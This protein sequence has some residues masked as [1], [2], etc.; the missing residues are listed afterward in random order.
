MPN[1]FDLRG[2]AKTGRNITMAD[3]D[4]FPLLQMASSGQFW[5]QPAETI[6][7]Q[8]P[9]H[10][11]LDDAMLYVVCKLLDQRQRAEQFPADFDADGHV[12]T[13]RYQ[14][15]T[16]FKIR[17][18]GDW[19]YPVY[20]RYYAMVGSEA[21]T[22]THETTVAIAA[23]KTAARNDDSWV[24]FGTKKVPRSYR[25]GT[26]PI[27]D[28]MTPQFDTKTADGLAT[29][30]PAA[31]APVWSRIEAE[32]KHLRDF[33]LAAGS[34][35]A[36]K[37]KHRKTGPKVVKPRSGVKTRQVTKETKSTTR[38]R[39]KRK[40]SS[41]SETESAPSGDEASD[42]EP[43]PGKKVPRAPKR[44][45]ATQPAATDEHR[46]AVAMVTPPRLTMTGESPSG[47]DLGDELARNRRIDLERAANEQAQ[48][49]QVVQLDQRLIAGL[50]QTVAELQQR[51]RTLTARHPFEDAVTDILH[52]ANGM[53]EGLRPAISRALREQALQ[54]LR[55]FAVQFGVDTDA[56]LRRFPAARVP[57]NLL[58][59]SPPRVQVI[60]PQVLADDGRA[61]S[62][63]D[64]T[65]TQRSQRAEVPGRYIS[66]GLPLSGLLMDT[67]HQ[68]FDPFP[69]NRRLFESR[70]AMSD[71]FARDHRHGGSAFDQVHLDPFSEQG[72]LM[73][74]GEPANKPANEP[75]GREAVE[76][77][78]QTTAIQPN[79]ESDE[80]SESTAMRNL[81]FGML[82]ES[83]GI[84]ETTE[85]APT[86]GFLGS[87]APQTPAEQALDGGNM[88]DTERRQ[89]KFNRDMKRR[90]HDDMRARNGEARKYPELANRD[91]L[92]SPTRPSI[93]NT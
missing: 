70:T 11:K 15:G 41:N 35:P 31:D 93:G 16:P 59:S 58:S 28:R 33:Y 62:T 22:D 12:R 36:K 4:H 23:G 34:V 25:V 73:L 65:P 64:Q 54:A 47:G 78:P 20:G 39:T 43:G 90:R 7:S 86:T 71:E 8:I 5:S 45:L 19:Y 13:V 72:P 60:I 67:D 82:P 29:P 21:V 49:G 81:T 18:Q 44:R 79:Q 57:T 26:F 61:A 83:L 69:V 84:I 6:R 51:I 37:G 24:S 74:P 76:G 38:R 68:P 17:F 75:A 30:L 27:I 48:L 1:A 32:Q 3:C 53:D 14:S 56:V 88:L 2:S 52:E 66:Q 85:P 87:S 63:N 92:M 91:D 46:T 50:Q 89:R 42:F 9:K 55:D 40:R 10:V 77:R 80:T